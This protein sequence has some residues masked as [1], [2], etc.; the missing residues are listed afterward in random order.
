MYIIMYIAAIRGTLG[1]LFTNQSVGS[2]GRCNSAKK[3][4]MER[5]ISDLLNCFLA[6]YK[7]C[8]INV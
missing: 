3:Y 8:A 2:L 1:L 4:Q 6:N 7:A 5:S